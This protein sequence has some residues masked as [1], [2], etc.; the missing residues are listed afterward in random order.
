MHGGNEG[1]RHFLVAVKVPKTLK[2]QMSEAVV[3]LELL[4]GL[5]RNASKANI[6]SYLEHPKV[7][8]RSM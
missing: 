4:C 2:K 7:V 6:A 3:W 8:T 1:G 5:S